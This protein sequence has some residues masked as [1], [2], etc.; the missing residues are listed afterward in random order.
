MIMIAL[1]S[2]TTAF[3]SQVVAHEAMEVSVEAIKTIFLPAILGQL[4]VLFADAR[5]H[6]G[7]IQWSWGIFFD[8]KIKTFLI[9]TI[10][11]IILYLII[12]L[13]PITQ[14][15]IE[16]LADSKL[17]EVTALGFFGLVAGIV[18]GFSKK[19]KTIHNTEIK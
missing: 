6:Y 4:L 14:Q 16:T 13:L 12:A 9:T 10:G 5:K 11:G 15:F 3:A 1:L 17:T 7:T 2:V 8:T 18:D 19:K